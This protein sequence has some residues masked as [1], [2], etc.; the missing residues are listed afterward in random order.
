VGQLQ[1]QWDEYEL[2]EADP[3]FDDSDAPLPEDEP[4]IPAGAAYKIGLA[5]MAGLGIWL[6]TSVLNPATLVDTSDLAGDLPGDAPTSAAADEPI[7]L[8]QV[9]IEPSLPDSPLQPLNVSGTLLSGLQ[10]ADPD[11]DPDSDADADP[12]TSVAADGTTTS[13]STST[14]GADPTSTSA[15][16]AA[17]TTAAAAAASGG[18]SGSGSDASSTTAPSSSS[19]STSP[20]TTAAPATTAAPTTAAPTTAAPTVSLDYRTNLDMIRGQSVRNR[21]HDGS[22][23]RNTPSASLDPNRLYGP[24]SEYLGNPGGN[25]EQSFP[26]GNGGQFRTACEFSHFAYDDPLL[27]PNKPGAAHL[28]MFFGNTDVNAFSTY[29]TLINSGSSTCNGQELNRTGYWVPAIIDGSGNVRIPERIVVYYKGEGKA[30]GASQVYPERAAMIVND[31]YNAMSLGEGGSPGKYSFVC[32]DVYSTNGGAASNTMPNCQGSGT[33]VLEMNVKFPGCWN[34]QNPA[35]W[36]NFYPARYGYY[37]SDC[38]GGTTLPNLEYFVNYRVEPGE[39]TSSWFLSS[40]VDATSFGASK[41]TAGSTVH[42]DW[43][44]GWHKAT[45][46]MWIDNCVNYKSNTA[47]GCGFGYLSDGGPNNGSPYDGPALKMRPQYTGPAKVSASELMNQ[48]CPSDRR[49]YAKPEDAAYC[50]PGTGL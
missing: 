44:G 3:G 21:N 13:E 26:V 30:R 17:D 20:S 49:S 2:I 37:S 10:L 42:G 31:N 23:F 41:T 47:S 14:S 48:L 50:A 18:G 19:Q 35:D 27:Y 1:S 12:T 36:N 5:L 6:V 11:A 34:G 38:V 33:A 46:Q 45:N 7:E 22:P 29:D 9:Q 4:L 15:D 43:W 39:N 24:R 32:S 25:P 28:H 8:A 16:V 40:D